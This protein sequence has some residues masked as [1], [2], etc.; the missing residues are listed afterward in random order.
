MELSIRSML[1]KEVWECISSL[2]SNKYLKNI[3]KSVNNTDYSIIHVI[4]LRQKILNG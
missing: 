4:I 1:C 2:R 3:A